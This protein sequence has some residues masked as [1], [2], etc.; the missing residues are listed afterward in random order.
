MKCPKCYRRLA[1]EATRCLCGWNASASPAGVRCAFDG[2]AQEAKTRQ[3]TPTGWATLCLHHDDHLHLEGAKKR[4]AEQG[5]ERTKDETREAWIGRLQ[6]YM[7]SRRFGSGHKTPLEWS[8]ISAQV[9]ADFA[10]GKVGL[11]AYERH[12]A[13]LDFFYATQPAR[14]PGCDDEEVSA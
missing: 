1:L 3:R 13:F 8:A 2:C 4:L 5:L 12:R 14:E 11:T 10:K 6:A 7:A 9:I